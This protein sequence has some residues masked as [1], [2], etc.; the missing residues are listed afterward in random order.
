[1]INHEFFQ[2]ERDYTRNTYQGIA[3]GTHVLRC[4]SSEAG[5]AGILPQTKSTGVFLN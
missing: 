1:M 5:R 2:N 4:V 3:I